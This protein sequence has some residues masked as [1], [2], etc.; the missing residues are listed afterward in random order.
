MIEW[1]WG[2]EPLTPRDAS[3]RNLAEVLD[4][5]NAPNLD[6]TAYTVPPFVP[7]RVRCAGGRRPGAE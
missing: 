6:R 3:A 7:D 4:F 1:R 2:L 5:A